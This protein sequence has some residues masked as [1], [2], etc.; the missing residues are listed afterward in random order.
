MSLLRGGVGWGGGSALV[1]RR[2]SLSVLGGAVHRGETRREMPSR[3]APVFSP[4]EF[5]GKTGGEIV[6]GLSLSSA[7]PSVRLLT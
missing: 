6:H 3:K 7:R 2:R 5:I 1:H 4:D